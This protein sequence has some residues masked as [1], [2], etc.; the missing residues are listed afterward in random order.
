MKIPPG[1]QAPPQVAETAENK[2]DKPAAQGKTA[3]K[4]SSKT[5]KVDFS[6]SLTG[7]FKSQ[8]ELQAK[9][10]ESIKARIKAGTYEVSSRDVAEKMLSPTQDF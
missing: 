8:Q 6:S 4:R 5:D 10:V 2:T 1:T 9:R 3:A 7:G